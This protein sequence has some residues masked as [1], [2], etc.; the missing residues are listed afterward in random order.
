MIDFS[1]GL[2]HVG[3]LL[4]FMSTRF[5]PDAQ[6]SRRGPLLLV[7]REPHAVDHAL[8]SPAT[9]TESGRSLS[10]QA[11]TFSS[12]SSHSFMEPDGGRYTPITATSPQCA[13][14]YLLSGVQDGA[15]RHHLQ[16]MATDPR[17]SPTHNGWLSGTRWDSETT[18][19]VQ[20]LSASVCRN[21][22]C[23]ARERHKLTFNNLRAIT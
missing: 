13:A 19:I 2:T 17:R 15:F 21:K 11:P 1:C 20:P 14:T 5:L 18:L 16:V 22:S 10:I 12:H 23:A 7:Y 4:W 8:K 6:A 9:R 3:T